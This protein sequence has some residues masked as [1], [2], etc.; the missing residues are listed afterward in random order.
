[1]SNRINFLPPWVETNLQPAFYDKESGSCLQQTAR[2]YAK[3]NQLVRISNEQY[4]TIQDYINQFLELKDYVE[5]YFENLD[6][7]EEIDH[8]LDEMTN[9]GTLGELLNN[10]MKPYIDSEIAETTQH[11]NDIYESLSQVENLSPKGAYATTTALVS[12]DPATGI[13][14]VTGNGHIYS[15]V[16]GGDTPVDLGAYQ[17]AVNNLTTEILNEDN[18]NS[19]NVEDYGY[20]AY[21]ACESGSISSAGNEITNGKRLRTLHHYR[22]AKNDQI[23]AD[24]K[25]SVCAVCFDEN[26]DSLGFYPVD[27]NVPTTPVFAQMIR[28]EEIYDKYEG[29]DSVRIIVKQNDNADLDPTESTHI[30]IIQKWYFAT[31]AMKL[32]LSSNYMTFDDYGNFRW[33]T[34]GF[35]NED[36][37]RLASMEFIDLSFY[38]KIKAKTGYEFGLT[39]WD[40]DT[41]A[42]IGY[43]KDTSGT[44]QAGAF[45][46]DEIDVTSLPTDRVYKV[47]FRNKTDTSATMNP[48]TDA[49][50]CQFY[51]KES[52]ELSD[53]ISESYSGVVI[54]NTAN[55]SNPIWTDYNGRLAFGEN[56]STAKVPTINNQ[57]F[58]NYGTLITMKNGD[59]NR[60]GYHQIE[61][62]DNSNFD[63]VT[64]LTDKHNEEGG[65]V[66]E[67]YYFT[68]TNHRHTSYGQTKI[69]SDVLDHSFYFNRDEF[70]A[71][72]LIDARSVI[73]LARIDPTTDI[74][75]TYNNYTQA[76]Q[77]Y[78]ANNAATAEN[79]LKCCR[80]IQLL[81]AQNGAMFYDTNRQKLVA[82]VNGKWSDVQVTPV[83][84]GTYPF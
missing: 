70:V 53:N 79:N 14:V 12:A 48:L 15:W 16:H 60:W 44:T 80:Y 69:G 18:W 72:G 56:T 73:Q 74:I 17:T 30:Q 71:K 31:R 23:N 34:T 22:I 81:N 6:V 37:A 21:M 57:Q 75:T 41:L 10:Y 68:G 38:T 13:Y 7:Q 25:Y 20:K 54:D 50:K 32:S 58:I 36:N 55:S 76:D 4:E 83:P 11:I 19:V 47:L 8:K 49:D 66:A 59:N 28:G 43:V 1:M 2:M 24:I 35:P 5:D 51:F 39:S 77:A 46:M 78:E 40:K 52:N 84:D 9:D 42:W 67:F 27:D 63:R 26:G 45:Y 62:Y 61:C 64:L 33:G 3:V 65:K 82:K 29:V